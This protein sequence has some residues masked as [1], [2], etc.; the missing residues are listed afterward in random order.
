M[1]KENPWRI[2]TRPERSAT[3]AGARGIT[4]AGITVA[5]LG[6]LACTQVGPHTSYAYLTGALLVT[7][8]GLDATVAPSMAAAFQALPR[9]RRHGRP[10]RSTPSS[11]PAGAVVTA[12]FA[13]I[14]QHTITANLP[15]HPQGIQAQRC[16]R[17]S[18]HTQHQRSQPPSAPPSGPP[19]R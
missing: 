3:Q 4:S 12:L 19:P 14:L 10:A 16:P 6:T 18:R 17:G 7:G 13:I 5:A 11:A 9:P 1:G 8:L 2:S 15:R